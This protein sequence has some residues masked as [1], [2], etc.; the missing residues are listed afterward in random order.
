MTEIELIEKFKDLDTEELK[1]IGND[2]NASFEEIIVASMIVTDRQIEN[3]ECYTME[4]VFGE[5][6][7]SDRIN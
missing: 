3:G 4:E 1:R 2:P 7:I 6:K 5:R